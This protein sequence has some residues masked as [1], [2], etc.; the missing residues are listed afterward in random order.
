MLDNRKRVYMLATFTVENRTTG[1]FS[2][3]LWRRYM[4]GPYSSEVERVPD[5]RS[6][7]QEGAA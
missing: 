7:T 3:R 5:D 4:H 1:C 6:P 2:R